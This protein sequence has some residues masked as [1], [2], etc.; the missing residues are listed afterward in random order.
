MEIRVTVTGPNGQHVDDVSLVSEPGD[1][2]NAVGKALDIYRKA[3]P[4]SPPFEHTI[5]VAHA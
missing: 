1:V 5:K 4:D 3:Y 2:T